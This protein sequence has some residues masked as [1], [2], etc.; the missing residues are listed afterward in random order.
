MKTLG[1]KVGFKIASSTLFAGLPSEAK[2]GNFSPRL[3]AAAAAAAAAAT[4]ACVLQLQCTCLADPQACLA[5]AQQ[6]CHPVE[7]KTIYCPVLDGSLF[8]DNTAKPPY[9]F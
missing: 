8:K 3:S 7:D 2:G 6:I 1:K 4:V 9:L 5:L